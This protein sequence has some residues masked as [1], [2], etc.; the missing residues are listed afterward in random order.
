MAQQIEYSNTAI[1]MALKALR[2]YLATTEYQDAYTADLADVAYDL[3]GTLNKTI[4]N[5][6]LQGVFDERLEG[7]EDE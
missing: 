6:A 1:C 7:D 2:N 5:L 4:V 3:A